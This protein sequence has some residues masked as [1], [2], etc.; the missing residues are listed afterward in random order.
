MS[1]FECSILDSEEVD[2]LEKN[3]AR[4]R[5]I[6]AIPPAQ[7]MLFLKLSVCITSIMLFAKYILNKEIVRSLSHIP[8]VT[9]NPPRYPFKILASRIKNSNG[10]VSTERPIPIPSPS[11]NSDILL[12]YVL[13]V[14]LKSTKT[15]IFLSKDDKGKRFAVCKRAISI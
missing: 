9:E 8:K 5:T 1:V 6:R 7:L 13:K 12:I 15:D 14:R 3:A 2:F 11:Q 4:P 10:P